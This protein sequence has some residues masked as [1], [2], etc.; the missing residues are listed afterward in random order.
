MH[1]HII[2]LFP[3]SFRSFLSTSIIAKAYEKNLFKVSFYDL[4]WDENTFKKVDDKAYGMHWQVMKVDII[5]EAIEQV[6]QT[7]GKKIPIVYFSPRGKTLRQR[8][9]DS[10]I[11]E[12]E[13]DYVLLCWHY[14]WIDERIIDIYTPKLFSIGDYVL[15]GWE[16]PAQVFIDGIVR[17]IPG[18]LWN[19]LSG[20][21][22]SF[23]QKFSGKKEHPLYT[24]P[25]VYQWKK[26]P[27]VLLSWNHKAI[28]QWKYD[29]LI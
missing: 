22:E 11:W 2:T 16:L 8:D 21:E 25:E 3:Q 26:V 18:V 7:L 12:Q 24:R 6:F 5:S 17:L 10:I 13:P 28:D 15:S 9:L 4:K 27:E 23:S 29:N 19:S 14:E 1:F 20:E